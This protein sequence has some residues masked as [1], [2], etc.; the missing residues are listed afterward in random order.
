LLLPEGEIDF[1]VSHNLTG[2]GYDQ[3]TLL[4]RA[5]KVETA[6]EIVAKKMWH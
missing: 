4:G 6:A 1:V 3:W 5:V 2:P